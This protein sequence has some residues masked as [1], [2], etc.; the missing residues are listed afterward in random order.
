MSPAAALRVLRVPV[1]AVLVGLLNGCS[2]ETPSREHIPVLRQCILD[3][4]SAISSSNPAA[5][6]SLLSVQILSNEQDSDS[7]LSFVYGPDRDFP[8][9]RLGDC[10]MFFTRDKARVDCYIMDSTGRPDRPVTLTFVYEHDL[11][12]LKR[13]EPGLARP[14]PVEGE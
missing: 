8:F 10:E 2:K 3:L 4:Q 11:W 6:D 9:E 5:I 1:V 7:L 13:F 14:Q 12:L